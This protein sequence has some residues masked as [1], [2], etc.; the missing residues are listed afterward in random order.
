M[1]ASESYV[2]VAADGSGKKIRNLKVSTYVDV[3]GVPTLTDVY[4]QVASIADENGVPIDFDEGTQVQRQIL[5]QLRT[6][7]RLFCLA[8]EIEPDGYT[9][10]DDLDGSATD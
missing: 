1:S 2:Q 6:L 9:D 8:F 3:N 4:I 10:E 5:E 7:E